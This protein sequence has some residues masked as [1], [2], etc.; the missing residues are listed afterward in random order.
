MQK[1]ILE[2]L[3]LGPLP[4]E[5]MADINFLKKYESQLLKVQPPITD[6]EARA[7]VTLFGPDSCYGT[8]W[9]MVNLI[10]TS[11]GW[12]LVDLLQNTEDD[13]IRILFSRSTKIRRV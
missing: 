9:T 2:L 10:E 1:E 8:A 11:P 7:L 5:E 13:W 12:P 3:K 6:D 4:S